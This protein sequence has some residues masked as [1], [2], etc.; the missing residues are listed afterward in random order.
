MIESPRN[1]FNVRHSAISD[2]WGGDAD[3][4]IKSLCFRWCLRLVFR[5]VISYINNIVVVI[6]PMELPPTQCAHSLAADAAL[7][8]PTPT[9][10]NIVNQPLVAITT[11]VSV[12]APSLHEL[13]FA[14]SVDT[15]DA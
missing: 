7:A 9:S 4:Q 11:L 10:F 3:I 13:A 8:D 2:W 14:Q 12:T 1:V 15:T 6:T 5:H